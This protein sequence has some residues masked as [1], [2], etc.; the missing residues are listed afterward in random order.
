[1]FAA[2]SAVSYLFTSRSGSASA[3]PDILVQAVAIPEPG[4][5]GLCGM[6]LVLLVL[7][8]AVRGWLGRRAA[9]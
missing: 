7:W 6:A 8:Q 3:R 9:R 5:V 2:D 1:L 4:A